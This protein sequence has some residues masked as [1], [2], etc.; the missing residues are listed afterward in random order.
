MA[1]L[2]HVVYGDITAKIL[3]QINSNPMIQA[4]P[5][6]SPGLTSYSVYS[7]VGSFLFS[8]C[9]RGG[10]PV[11]FLKRFLMSSPCVPS[12]SLAFPY[13]SVSAATLFPAR[14]AL[15]SSVRFPC[16]PCV[17]SFLQPNPNPAPTLH[18]VRHP[19]WAMP[20]PPWAFS[21]SRGSP[22]CVTGTFIPAFLVGSVPHVLP[23]Q[24]SCIH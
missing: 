2:S 4:G 6:P 23:V 9:I 8:L 1:R 19:T 22:L 11:C 7:L 21:Q 24:S 3:A 18:A 16:D 5:T 14:F 20:R 10:F 15:R 12:I 13:V 17:P